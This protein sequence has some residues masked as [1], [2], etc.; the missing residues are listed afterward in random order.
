[1]GKIVEDQGGLE[2][3]R[4][5]TGRVQRVG[6]AIILTIVSV[7]GC[8]AATDPAGVLSV[9]TVDAKVVM[10]PGT[11]RE[12][13]GRAY[14]LSS[15]Q[16]TAD[17]PFFTTSAEFNLAKPRNVWAGVFVKRGGLH[18]ASFDGVKVV[19]RPEEMPQFFHGG[20]DVVN[21]VADP[22]SGRTLSSWCNVDHRTPAVPGY[23]SA[24]SPFRGE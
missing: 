19:A 8:S 10:P 20:C 16:A 12:N 3:V 7:I 2:Q 4:K 24:D 1:M 18:G 21:V 11:R 14:V 9:E 15:V 17:T 23:H 5:M 6:T 13:Y 22:A